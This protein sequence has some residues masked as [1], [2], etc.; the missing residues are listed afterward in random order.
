MYLLYDHHVRGGSGAEKVCP[1]I[2]KGRSL[3]KY[4]ALLCMCFFVSGGAFSAALPFVS[5]AGSISQDDTKESWHRDHCPANRRIVT[6]GAGD[7]VY[8]PD[9]HTLFFFKK[10]KPALKLFSF[11][12]RERSIGFDGT[13]IRVSTQGRCH[14]T[15]RKST[16]CHMR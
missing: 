1:S 6:R 5:G 14:L 12:R 16:G 3:S 4:W 13:E 9:M 8:K 2:V 7:N 11:Q 10:K 15:L